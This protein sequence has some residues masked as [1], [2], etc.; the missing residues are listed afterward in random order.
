[1]VKDIIQLIRFPLLK[2]EE[3]NEV[4]IPQDIINE[5]ETKELTKYLETDITDR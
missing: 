3:F 2:L 1:M 5:K 4:V